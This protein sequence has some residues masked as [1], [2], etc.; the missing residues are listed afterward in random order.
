MFVQD[1]FLVIE[2]LMRDV[3]ANIVKD[4][5]AHALTILRSRLVRL[6]EE[7]IRLQGE[8]KKLKVTTY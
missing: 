8:S 5:E 1:V 3:Q 6:D 4:W 2:S 7:F